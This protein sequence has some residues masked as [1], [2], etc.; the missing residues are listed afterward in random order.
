MK[1]EEI[2]RKILNLFI[3]LVMMNTDGMKS[4]TISM[5]E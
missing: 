2:T 1:Q 5:Q 3:L 4:M